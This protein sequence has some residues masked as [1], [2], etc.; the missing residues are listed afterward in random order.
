MSV[1]S[2]VSLRASLRHLALVAFTAASLL[3]LGPSFPHSQL[4]LE[5]RR[6]KTR[7]YPAQ[8]VMQVSCTTMQP[9]PCVMLW[10]PTALMPN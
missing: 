2:A 6:R 5:S 7:L 3:L 9:L 10:S 4:S 8:P 1:K